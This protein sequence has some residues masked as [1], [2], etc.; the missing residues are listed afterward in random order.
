MPYVKLDVPM[1]GGDE[2]EASVGAG[3]TPASHRQ[4]GPPG[5]EFNRPEGFC[6][7]AQDRIY[8]RSQSSHQD[9][10]RGREIQPAIWGA[11][12]GLG[13]MSYHLKSR[14]TRRVINVCGRE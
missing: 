2:W 1:R 3:G 4:A 6:V 9:F 13:E 8:W 12:T 11:G 7:D 10:F 14:G 5:S